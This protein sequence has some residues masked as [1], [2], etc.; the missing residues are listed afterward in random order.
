MATA[1]GWAMPLL[2]YVVA[3]GL[4]STWVA[5]QGRQLVADHAIINTTLGVQNLDCCGG[6]RDDDRLN[7]CGRGSGQIWFCRTVQG[8][9]LWLLMMLFVDWPRFTSPDRQQGFSSILRLILP[10]IAGTVGVM[11]APPMG[12]LALAGV[13]W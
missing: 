7:R 12:S 11:L 10:L 13:A 1:D 6:C 5:T 3:M 9:G 2:G 8:G 4:A